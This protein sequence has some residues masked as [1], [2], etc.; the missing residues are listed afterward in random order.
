MFNPNPSFNGYADT[1]HIEVCK[2]AYNLISNMYSSHRIEDGLK[3]PTNQSILADR[4]AEDQDA[5]IEYLR[6]NIKG[7]DNVDAIIL[8]HLM[9][10]M[11]LI[12]T[13]PNIKSN[14]NAVNIIEDT[15]YLLLSKYKSKNDE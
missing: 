10:G 7:L 3:T 2:T 6:E 15:I 12:L 5:V 1:T 4:L 9:F 11:N 14:P 13:D 8:C